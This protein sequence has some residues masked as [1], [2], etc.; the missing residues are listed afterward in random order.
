MF[1]KAFEYVAPRSLEEALTLLER[2]GDEARV[3]AGGQSLIPLLKL[4]FVYLGHVIDLNRIDE[5][6]GIEEQG[7]RIRCGA[8]ARHSDIE[9][10]SLVARRIPLLHETAIAIADVQVRNRGTLGGALCQADPAAD[11][12][13]AA[14]A[15]GARLR[16]VSRRG[17]RLVE[18][19]A[20]FKDAYT[21]AV[22]PGEILTD[23]FFPIPPPAST[24]VYVKIRKRMGDFA[25]ASVALQLTIDTN[26]RCDSVG[27]GL[28]GVAPTPIA[29]REIVEFLNGR[30]LSESVIDE[31]SAMLAKHLDPIEDLRGSADYKRSIASVAFG[32]AVHRAMEKARQQTTMQR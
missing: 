3:L 23:I 5:L 24:G 13:V 14:L 28:G 17:E 26:G 19:K 21:P 8:M 1:P 29:P 31:A 32:R 22:A 30:V 6:R 11:W 7:A 12:A 27:L 9:H 2:Y 15:L 18:A 16:C 25:I 20:F 10:S 4:R